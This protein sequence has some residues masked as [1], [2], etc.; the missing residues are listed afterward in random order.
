MEQRKSL[1]FFRKLLSSWVSLLILSLVA[2]TFFII[3]SID[4]AILLQ[5]LETIPIVV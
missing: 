5:G 4:N 1:S 3:G 2:L